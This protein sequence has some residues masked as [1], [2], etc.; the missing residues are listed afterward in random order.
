MFHLTIENKL[1]TDE[2][3]KFKSTK[4]YLS[5]VIIVWINMKRTKKD[6]ACNLNTGNSKLPD[7]S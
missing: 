7:I 4:F 2:N 6:E 5:S 1:K 3:F